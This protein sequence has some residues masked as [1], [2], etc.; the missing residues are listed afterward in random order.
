MAVNRINYAAKRRGDLWTATDAN[1]VKQI[2]NE[3]A[4]VIDGHTSS[5]QTI[6]GTLDQQAQTILQNSQAIRQIS[7]DFV[8]SVW[9]TQEEYDAL[10]ASGEIEETTE[11]NIYEE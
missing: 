9:V 8:K 11:Y 4:D 3:H 6:N 10:V 7:Q 2:V 1:E 5:I